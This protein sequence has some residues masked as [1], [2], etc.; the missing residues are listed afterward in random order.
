MLSAESVEK[1]EKE[2]VLEPT[3]CGFQYML[4]K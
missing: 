3:I 1:V 2:H 4:S